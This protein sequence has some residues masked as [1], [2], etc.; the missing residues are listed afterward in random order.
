MS[1]PTY[2]LSGIKQTFDSTAKLRMTGSARQGAISLGFS[3]QDVVDAIQALTPQDFHKTMKPTH[4][5]F[6][7]MQDVY[8]PTFK[9]VDLY[10]KFQRLSN[11]QLLLS[12]KR[13]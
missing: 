7:A 2:D 5:N 8:K 1:S 4:S 12:F 3:D 10:V 6:A 13:K 9:G 11:G